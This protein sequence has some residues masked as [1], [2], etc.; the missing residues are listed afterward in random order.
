[1]SLE[2]IVG[3]ATLLPGD[4]QPPSE[5][6]EARLKLLSG[7]VLLDGK[8]LKSLR[9]LQSAS[10]EGLQARLR[11]PDGPITQLTFRE[12]A[13]LGTFQAVVEAARQRQASAPSAP[14]HPAAAPLGQPPL[15]PQKSAQPRAEPKSGPSDARGGTAAG[16]GPRVAMTRKLQRCCAE[17]GLTP[18]STPCPAAGLAI[19][20][21]RVSDLGGCLAEHLFEAKSSV[22]PLGSQ[23]RRDKRDRPLTQLILCSPGIMKAM[24]LG[25]K[26]R[27]ATVQQ[28]L[29]YDDICESVRQRFRSS[30]GRLR[31]L[32]FSNTGEEDL[33][34]AREIVRLHMAATPLVPAR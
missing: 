7:I 14:S 30:W 6:K 4:S 18:A 17:S 21:T 31:E 3:T 32:Q 15:T 23:A 34:V 25:I 20:L 1:M 24:L 12:A 29:L 27:R 26:E 19:A 13:E 11:W 8:I 10:F 33:D 9:A 28:K 22:L 2:T 5:T 16:P